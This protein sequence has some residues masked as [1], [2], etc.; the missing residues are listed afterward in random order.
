M[1]AYRRFVK[2]GDTVIE[3]GGHIGFVTLH[4]RKL[5]GEHGSVVVFE[6]GPNNLPYLHANVAPF[7][8]IHIVEA[9]C[10]DRNGMVNFWVENLTGQNNS[11]MPSYASYLQNKE[12]AFVP[13]KSEKIRVSMMTL[14]TFVKENGLV[15]SLVKIDVEHA[16]HM[17]LKGARG[18]LT[19][20]RPALIMEVEDRAPVEELLAQLG[21]KVFDKSR[22][23][24]ICLPEIFSV[25]RTMLGTSAAAATSSSTGKRRSWVSPHPS[26]SGARD[27]AAA[28]PGAGGEQSRNA[29]EA[30][31][32][33]P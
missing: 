30:A 22:P 23:E 20:Y 7:P 2:P 11:L 25:P 18:S 32:R 5:V 26:A 6:P 16:E 15:P 8:N 31:L 27:W 10:G 3:I 21:Y 28:H 4:L 1:E 13:S 29:A 12:R 24:W 33:V 19:K 17:V 14:D 9:A